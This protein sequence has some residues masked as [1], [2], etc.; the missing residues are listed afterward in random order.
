MKNI[1]MAVT[2]ILFIMSTLKTICRA[3]AAVATTS[4]LYPTTLQAAGTSGKV[5]L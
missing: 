2:H 4:H 5:E 3:A 1:G